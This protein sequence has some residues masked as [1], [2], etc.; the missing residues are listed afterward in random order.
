MKEYYYWTLSCWISKYRLDTFSESVIEAIVACST[1]SAIWCSLSGHMTTFIRAIMRQQPEKR[2]ERLHHITEDVEMTSQA[3]IASKTDSEKVSIFTKKY[4]IKKKIK[5]N[6]T[7]QSA[8]K[9]KVITKINRKTN[10]PK[11]DNHN[12]SYV[13]LLQNI[14]VK[15]NLMHSFFSSILM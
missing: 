2:L 12:Y 10:Y 1:S 15:I 9:N 5:Y 8:T 14:F 4:L 7:K 6:K 3:T 13:F 11:K